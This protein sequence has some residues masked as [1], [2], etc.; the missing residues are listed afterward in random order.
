MCYGPFG[1][2][3]QAAMEMRPRPVKCTYMD[4]KVA[5]LKLTVT[6]IMMT[7]INSLPSAA[8]SV[9]SD[10]MEQL[11]TVE[12]GEIARV[13]R[14]LKLEWSRSGSKALDLLLLRG[15]EAMALGNI[16]AAIEHFT[17]LTD[18]APNFAEGWHGRA[19][20]YFEIELLGPALSDLKRS[21]VLN[22]NNFDAFFGLGSMMMTLEDF[23]RAE[24]A[25]REVLR[26]HPKHEN[27]TNALERLESQGIGREL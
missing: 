14:A 4:L 13:E 15:R 10:L 24:K 7:V 16:N 20:A 12:V 5:N 19:I 1:Y 26:L 22:S 8:Q 17:A 11:K 3:A 9:T 23:S 25:F 6:A 18:H 2:F 21:L 27:A